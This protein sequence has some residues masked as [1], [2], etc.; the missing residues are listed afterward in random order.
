MV[1]EVYLTQDIADSLIELSKNWQDEDIT[2]GYIENKLSDL[3]DR[4]IFLFREN[5]E[6]LGYLFGKIQIH[7]AE[8]VIVSN[9]EQYFEIEEIYVKKENRSQ[10]IGKKLFGYVEKT[11]KKE[12]IHYILLTSATKDFN[13]ISNFYLNEVDMHNWYTRFFKKI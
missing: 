10:G 8:T 2:Y 5:N 3:K 11:L 12:G 13:S 6:I 9:G 1:E 4:R 7:D